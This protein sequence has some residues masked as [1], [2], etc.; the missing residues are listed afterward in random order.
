L[1]RLNFLL[2]FFGSL[3]VRRITKGLTL[4]YRRQRQQEKTVT[5]ATVNRDL[6]VLRRVLFWAVDDGIL[7][8][9]PLSR[10]RLARERKVPRTIMSVADEQKLYKAAPEHLR[11]LIMAALDTGMRRGELTQQLWE[12]VDFVRKILLVTR[13][14]TAEGEAREIPLTNRLFDFLSGCRKADGRIFLYRG[15]PVRNVKKAWRSTL[16]RAQLRPSRFHDLRHTFNTRLLEA[17]VIQEVRM[18]LMGHAVAGKVHS[19]Y[20]HVELPVK[21]GA[22][23][24]L[25]KWVQNQLEGGSDD[26]KQ[27]SRRC[28]SENQSRSLGG[29]VAEAV[30]KEDAS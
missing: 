22:I 20:T 2:P 13:S 25:E 10:M 3:P 11:S 9:N 29:S 24:R 26:E 14:K 6:S 27:D 1:G 21:R 23:A 5:D 4:E 12:H 30:A 17:G 8:A 7:F 16:K 19:T 28:D 15:R 18:S